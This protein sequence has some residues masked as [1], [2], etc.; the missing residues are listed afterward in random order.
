ML[1][2]PVVV[3]QGCG[4]SDDNNSDGYLDLS[5]QDLSVSEL[6][7]DHGGG[8]GT[9][10]I[11]S[12]VGWTASSDE[13]WCR[14]SVREGSGDATITVTVDEWTGTIKREAAITVSG[15]GVKDKVVLVVQTPDAGSIPTPEVP[16][17]AVVSGKSE[18]GVGE[19]SVTLTAVADGADSFVWYKGNDKIEGAT[20]DTYEA[21]E[22]GAYRAAGVNDEGEGE[23][24]DPKE[25]TINLF[26]DELL[27]LWYANGTIIYNS[28]GGEHP[29]ELAITKIDATTINI[30]NFMGVRD[31]VQG[32]EN[33]PDDIKATVDNAAR[34]IT[35][36][37]QSLGKIFFSGTDDT[38]LVHL[39]SDYYPKDID[40][41]YTGSFTGTGLDMK[42]EVTG[43]YAFPNGSVGGFIYLGMKD[44]KVVGGD[45]IWADAVW[46]RE[47]I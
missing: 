15:N 16:E 32:G 39:F 46:S 40:R 26:I 31:I 12:N 28:K 13:T 25:V 5:V 42:F 7:F 11:T 36:P 27:G 33:F 6:S 3:F 2:L 22:T 30:N 18:N 24:S 19:G 35:I 17:K 38:R 37:A 23:Q 43:G 8:K 9:L 45:F 4:G 44:G 34:T 20:S 10:S 41:G 14:L 29:H 47:P 1:L 21:T